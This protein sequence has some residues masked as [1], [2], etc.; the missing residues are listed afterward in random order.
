MNFTKI[1][2]DRTGDS[3]Y[4]LLH[5][6]GLTIYVYPKK[7]YNSTYAIFGTNFGS[8]DT[9]FMYRGEKIVVPDGIAHYL[10]HKLF[11]SE[12]GDAFAKYA[13]T[14]ACANAYTSFDKTC[15]LFSCSE[16][17]EESLNI[18][19][20]FVQSP[21][22]TEKTVQKEQGII[23]QEIKMYD[24][25]AD[26]RVMFNALVAMYHKHP[27]SIDIA[28]TVETIA[29]I[30]AEKLYKCYECFYNL[31]N[32]ALCIAGNITPEEVLRIVDKKL[33]QS[34]NQEAYSI[35]EDE[36]YEV[37]QKYIEQNF[38][39]AMPSFVLGFKEKAKPEVATV[40]E[41]VATDIILYT[42]LS[43]ASP[44]YDILMNEGLIN[45]SFGYE[46]FEGRGYA[47]ILISG[48]SRNP[49]KVTEMIKDA[50]LKMH[51]NGV[52]DEEFEMSKKAIYGKSI[53]VLDSPENI[54][55]ILIGFDF[56]KRELYK[57]IDAIA[58]ITKKDVENR[59]KEQL[60]INN[61]SLSVV[62]SFSEE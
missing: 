43:D 34:P 41:I 12:D 3:Y 44:L 58:N 48:E 42:L 1:S 25:N 14:G 30:T 56:S 11:E 53:E 36:P 28:G 21:Y 57:Y 18:L 52:S 45:D 22:F 60:D 23:G 46:Y 47:S 16:H 38:D 39:V 35:F 50:I 37:K 4:K 15:Y 54:A 2:S 7:S 32:M 27:V 49:E 40:E 29:D 51:E 62:K 6:S 24:D 9:T 31:N 8:I 59:L 13:K 55:N 61:Y 10:E 5:P 33:K 17:F 20:D 26:W 19:I